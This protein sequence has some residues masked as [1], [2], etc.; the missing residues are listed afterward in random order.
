MPTHARIPMPPLGA[1]K[2]V[3]GDLLLGW[4]DYSVI[5]LYVFSSASGIA[6]FGRL[7]MAGLTYLVT[8]LSYETTLSTHD[9]LNE[10]HMLSRVWKSG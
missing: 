4:V 2:I 7:W 1:E 6:V 10:C 8:H 3:F 9:K 5:L